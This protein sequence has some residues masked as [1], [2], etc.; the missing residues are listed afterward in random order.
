MVIVQFPPC[1]R[2]A[3]GRNSVHSSAASTFGDQVEDH[4]RSVIDVIKSVGFWGEF[5]D[6]QQLYIFKYKGVSTIYSWDFLEVN[7][8]ES[9]PF[10]LQITICGPRTIL[11]VYPFGDTVSQIYCPFKVPW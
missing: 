9:H 2:L 5:L 1:K 8:S 3:E 6:H 4:Y 7:S 11:D 10:L